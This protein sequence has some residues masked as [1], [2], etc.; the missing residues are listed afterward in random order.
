MSLFLEFGSEECLSLG[1]LLLLFGFDI[2]FELLDSEFNLF[3]SSEETFLDLLFGSSEEAF[4]E[5]LGS[6]EDPILFFCPR[7]SCKVF[8]F[9]LDAFGSLPAEEF[10]LELPLFGSLSLL[11]FE[12]FIL[13]SELLE[14]PL[15]D[16]RLERLPSLLSFAGRFT[17]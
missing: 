1:S 3:G 14:P 2:F 13:G 12:L 8:C 9:F 7:K 10:P 17:F 4:F 15:F 16:E 6:S 5:A 11:L